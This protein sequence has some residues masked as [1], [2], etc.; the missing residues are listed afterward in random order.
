MIQKVFENLFING[1]FE[2]IF[3]NGDLTDPTGVVE[4]LACVKMAELSNQ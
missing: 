2:N 3:I 1:D 4:F